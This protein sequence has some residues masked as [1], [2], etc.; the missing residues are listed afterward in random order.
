MPL[1]RLLYA[2]ATCMKNGW[3]MGNMF[4]GKVNLLNTFVGKD[5][6]AG[7]ISITLRLVFQSNT[8]SLQ[9]SEI[10]GS[11]QNLFRLL[12]KKLNAKIRS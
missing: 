2:V 9:E 4:S 7:F 6:P 12:E 3:T 5:I 8:K 11:M 10:N 1:T